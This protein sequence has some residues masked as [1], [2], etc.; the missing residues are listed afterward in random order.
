VFENLRV[1]ELAGPDLNF[2]FTIAAGPL[3]EGLVE[4]IVVNVN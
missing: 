4:F 2:V 3:E 1:D